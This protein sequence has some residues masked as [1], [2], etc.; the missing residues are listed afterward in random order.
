[1]K[2]LQLL[3]LFSL[4]L[5]FT[6]CSTSEEIDPD[7]EPFD[8]VF[9]LS[10]TGDD[11]RT[12][13][14]VASFVH[15]KITTKSEQE[16]GSFLTVMLTNADNENELI[17]ILIGQVG[18]LDGVNTGTY[19]ID[20]DPDEGD[21]LVNLAAYLAGSFTTHLGTAGTVT[22]SKVQNSKVEGS[23]SFTAD[24]LNGSIINVSGD[25]TALGITENL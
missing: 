24:N 18:D 21:P 7:D 16:N 6:N 5:F 2:H 3:T 9:E 17:S 10:L 19:S 12:M 15:G 11:T 4:L 23:F 13:K 8:G 14:G 20:V 25:F 1:M 22:I